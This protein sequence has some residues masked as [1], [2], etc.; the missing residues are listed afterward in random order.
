MAGGAEHGFDRIRSIDDYQER[1]P[2]TDY[3]GLSPYIDRVLRAEKNVLTADDPLMFATTSG[4]T[5]SAK[6][7]PVTP[8]YLHEYSHAVQVH[9]Y[10]LFTDFR[11]ILGGKMLVFRCFI[12]DPQLVMWGVGLPLG[13]RL[14]LRRFLWLQHLRLGRWNF[15]IPHDHQLYPEA[16]ILTSMRLNLAKIELY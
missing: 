15:P 11:D 6:Y 2:P 3:E 4:T 5:G 10:R 16:I 1:V 8:S 14:S 9:L 7:I 13:F 12:E